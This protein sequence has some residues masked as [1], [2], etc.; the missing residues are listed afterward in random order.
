MAVEPVFLS[1]A[2]LESRLRLSKAE[3]TDTEAQIDKA[4]KTVRIGFYRSLSEATITALLATGSSGD[5]PTSLVQIDRALAEDIEVDWVRKELLCILP[6]LFADGA[7]GTDEAYNEDGLTRNA[8]IGDLDKLLEKL[9]VKVEDG[10]EEL[11]GSVFSGSTVQ[12]VCIG[13]ATTPPLPF[14]I[15]HP[16]TVE[17][18]L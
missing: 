16:P 4:I 2:Q 14:D 12:A 11:G 3:Q 10:I 9:S 7:G 15:L 6:V 5:N 1:R 17:T 8:S 18:G 13:P